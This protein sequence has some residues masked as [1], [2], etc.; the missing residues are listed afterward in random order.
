VVRER[1]DDHTNSTKRIVG[2]MIGQMIECGQSG[3]ECWGGVEGRTP[4]GQEVDKPGDPQSCT[5]VEGWG[6]GVGISQVGPR[7]RRGAAP[8]SGGTCRTPAAGPIP[9]PQ[10]TPPPEG[11]GATR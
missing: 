5:L 8:G 11:G 2:Q 3:R 7:A 6:W 10:P 1:R 9:P 4:D